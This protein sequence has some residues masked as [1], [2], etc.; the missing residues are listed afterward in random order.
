[1]AIEAVPWEVTSKK[2]MEMQLTVLFQ[3]SSEVTEENP[4]VLSGEKSIFEPSMS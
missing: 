3:H 4:E 1:M 2:M